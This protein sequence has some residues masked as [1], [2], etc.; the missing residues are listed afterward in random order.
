MKHL[1]DRHSTFFIP[2]KSWSP[3][4][5]RVKQSALDQI[6]DAALFA[7]LKASTDQDGTTIWIPHELQ[8]THAA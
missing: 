7:E 2:P 6:V 3:F 4:H 5:Y 1:R 8:Y